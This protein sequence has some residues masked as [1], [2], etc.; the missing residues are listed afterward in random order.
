MIKGH[1][2]KHFTEVIIFLANNQ[3][4][5]SMCS[6]AAVLLYNCNIRSIRNDLRKQLTIKWK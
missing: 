4:C 6:K 2:S 1:H 3:L 5:L